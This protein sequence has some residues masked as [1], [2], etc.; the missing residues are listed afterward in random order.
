M[1]LFPAGQGGFNSPRE[2]SS[3]GEARYRAASTRFHCDLYVLL[4]QIR[5]RLN[6]FT[7]AEEAERELKTA[8][9]LGAKDD[10]NP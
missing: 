3:I 1:A 2:T 7:N 5:N 10:A 4:F 8:Q 9:Q 6:Q